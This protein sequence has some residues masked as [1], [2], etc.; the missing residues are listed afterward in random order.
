MVLLFSSSSLSLDFGI[1]G[2]EGAKNLAGEK[3]PPPN[4]D[5]FNGV[6]LVKNT[7]SLSTEIC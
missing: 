4:S 7:D 1:A 2:P 6:E 3:G 5:P